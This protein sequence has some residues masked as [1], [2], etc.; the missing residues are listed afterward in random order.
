[1]LTRN[2][3]TCDKLK[4]FSM[5]QYSKWECME[6]YFK[7]LPCIKLFPSYSGIWNQQWKEQLY[8][9]LRDRVIPEY[10]GYSGSPSFL[11]IC[12]HGGSIRCWAVSVSRWQQ[13]SPVHLIVGLIGVMTC[14]V[15]HWITN[16]IVWSSI[17]GT[18]RDLI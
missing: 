5:V 15:Y 12:R 18:S 3:R 10:S 16:F 7:F 6:I 4:E 1:M 11:G 8:S 13:F 9:L 14:K 17:L 2:S